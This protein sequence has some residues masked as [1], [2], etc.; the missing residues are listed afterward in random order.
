MK[1]F[2]KIF[3]VIFVSI[4]I[5]VLT[6]CSTS[7][8]QSETDEGKTKVHISLYSGEICLEVKEANFDV[9]KW[10]ITTI[11]DQIFV[12]PLENCFVVDSGECPICK[13][14]KGIENEKNITFNEN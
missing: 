2:L 13:T 5:L 10:R 7:I 8:N 1:K 3:A 9:R 6:A 4:I 14:I 12:V 11:E